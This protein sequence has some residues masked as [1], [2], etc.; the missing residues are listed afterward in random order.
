MSA[1]AASLKAHIRNLAR[2]K[3]ISAQVLLQNY[4]FERFLKRLSLSTY[5]DKFI[6]KGGMLVAAMVGLETRSTMDL[7]VTLR[8]YPLNEEHLRVAV[9]E[10][11]A[12][13]VKDGIFFRLTGVSPI[14]KDDE[15]GGFRAS[16]EALYDTIATP[17]SVDVTSGDAITPGAVRHS[18]AGIF[19]ERE[20][21]ELWAYNVETVLAEKIETILRRGVFNTRARDFYDIFVLAKTQRYDPA[22]LKQALKATAMHRGTM[23][24]IADVSSILSVIAGSEDLKSG[25]RKYQREYS[26]ASEIAYEDV[27]K[28]LEDLVL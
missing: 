2:E 25:W 26:Y 23:A 1:K 28:A 20:R 15:Y 6:L 22:V 4:M 13:E 11:C 8:A 24:Q 7:D 5:R 18:F 12:I 10:I 19:D 21:G 27:M 16:L 9:E 3:K 17:L 14:R